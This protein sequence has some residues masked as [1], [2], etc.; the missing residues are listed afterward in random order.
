M[1]E[2]DINSVGVSTRN[3]IEYVLFTKATSVVMVHN[4]P[5]G[6]ALPSNQDIAI[7][8]QVK[9]ALSHIG[10]KLVDHI[11]IADDDYISLYQTN[12]YKYIFK[13]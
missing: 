7:T 8:E 2:G 9:A 6:I 5:S 4:H 12:K 11:I 13:D 3:I 10:V 1:G